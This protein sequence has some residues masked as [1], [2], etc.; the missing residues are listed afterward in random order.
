MRLLERKQEIGKPPGGQEL[1][2]LHLYYS[3]PG[4]I[5][6]QG[7]KIPR[8]FCGEA[9]KKKKRKIRNRFVSK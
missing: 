6:G 1:E 4:S 8:A 9:K 2:T 5:L 7:A 3:E